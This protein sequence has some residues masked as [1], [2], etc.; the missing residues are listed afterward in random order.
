MRLWSFGKFQSTIT[1]ATKL[2]CVP[3]SLWSVLSTYKF[4][5]NPLTIKS[6]NGVP[7]LCI[8][9]NFLKFRLIF[10]SSIT[11]VWRCYE[12]NFCYLVC[13]GKFYLQ[14]SLVTQTETPKLVTSRGVSLMS[15]LDLLWYWQ[16]LTP[17][18]QE[19]LIELSC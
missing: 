6:Q 14:H 1:G 9:A 19:R 7:Y 12:T 5:S 10:Q 16:G 4:E 8:N 3:Y 2:I 11:W 17:S 15:S 18:G 13:L